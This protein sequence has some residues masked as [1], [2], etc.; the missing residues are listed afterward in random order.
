MLGIVTEVTVKL[1][2][3]KV[4]RVLLGSFDS[5]EDAGRAWPRSLLPGSFPAAWR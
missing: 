3:P 5:V 1:L 4:A 2:P